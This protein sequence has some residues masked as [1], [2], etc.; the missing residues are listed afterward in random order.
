VAAVG[1]NDYRC[2][3]FESKHM[4]ESL[5]FGKRIQPNDRISILADKEILK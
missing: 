1:V 4:L 2:S 3:N 5:S